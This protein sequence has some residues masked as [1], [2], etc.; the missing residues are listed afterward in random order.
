MSM[1]LFIVDK[2]TFPIHLK[3]MFAGTGCSYGSIISDT[4]NSFNNLKNN[5]SGKNKYSWAKERNICGMI[6]DASRIRKGDKIAF[7]CTGINKFYGIFRAKDISF[8]EGQGSYLEKDLNKCLFL[9]VLIEADKVYS[10]GKLE[11]DVVDRF[12]NSG[13]SI[14]LLWSIIYRKLGGNRG[15]TVLNKHEEKLITKILQKKNTCISCFPKDHFKFNED[16]IEIEKD[17]SVYCSQ[18]KINIDIL[19]RLIYKYNKNQSFETHLQA[20]LTQNIEINIELKKIFN[21]QQLNWIGNEIYCSMGGRRIDIMIDVLDQNNKSILYPIELKDEEIKLGITNQLQKYLNWLEIYYLPSKE[22]K[23]KKIIPV[24]I[25]KYQKEFD[26]E[27]K[28][29]FKKF[30]KQNRKICDSIKCIGF[31]LNDTGT[32]IVFKEMFY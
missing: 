19:P 6:A 23:T 26:K 32:D 27:V 11:W 21:I 14:D 31:Y 29:E 18:K 15:N 5:S 4:N 24:I 2:T 16:K 22:H 8:L 13:K 25:A 30:N 7:Y 1:H 20:Y 17:K 12:S 9:R 28:D 10:D 3:Y